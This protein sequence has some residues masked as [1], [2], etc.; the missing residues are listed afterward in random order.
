[1][2]KEVVVK[3]HQLGFSADEVLGQLKPLLE[4]LDRSKHQ[5]TEES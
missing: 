1:L 4:E 3:A 5:R 2:L